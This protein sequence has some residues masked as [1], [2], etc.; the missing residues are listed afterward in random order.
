MNRRSSPGVGQWFTVAV[1][2][3]TTL[4]LLIK[5]YQYASISDT[6]PT[7]LTLAGVDVGGM[8]QQQASDVL[9][10][11]FIEAPIIIYHG[12]ESYEISPTETEFQLDMEGLF[13][14]AEYERSRQDFWAGFWGFL[15]GRPIE[16]SPVPIQATHD[17]E[18]LIQVLGKIKTLMDK[19]AQPAQPVPGTLSFQYGESGTETNIEASL[20]DVEAA[21]Y[22]HINREAHLVVEPKEPERPDMNLLVRLL[23]NQIQDFEQATGGVGSLFIMDLQ[24]GEEIPINADEPMSGIDLMKVPIVLETYRVLDQP[25]TLTQNELISNTLVI[26][27]ENESANTLLRTIA[28]QDDPYLGTQLVT[29]SMQRL[30]LQNSYMMTPYES[31]PQVGTAVP[32]TPANQAE[33]IRTRPNTYIQTTAEDIGTF[34]AMVYYCAEGQGGALQAAFNGEITQLECETLLAYMMQNRIGSLIEEGVPSDVTVAHR[35]GW[36]SDTHA[37][38]GIVYTPAGDYVIVQILYKPD[39]LE[40]ELS[41]PLMSDISRA[42]YNFF[43][44]DNPYL[45]DS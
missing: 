40:W 41:S 13:S 14:Q 44:F 15:W 28:G 22:R 17:R 19:P 12:E 7:G 6:Y 3:S 8:N 16:V 31:D 9:S 25:P 37:D 45:D 23:V 10:N 27:V 4:F 5:L 43:N 29:T 30:G 21:L 1:L 34:L 18:A 2:V 33:D 42:T 35:H 11:R 26:Q 38:A 39:W 24:T 36:V 32:Q 20:D